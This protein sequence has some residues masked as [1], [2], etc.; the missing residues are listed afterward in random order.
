MAKKSKKV[1]KETRRLMESIADLVKKKGDRYKFKTKSKKQIKRIKK[2]C[3][4]WITRK[5][6]DVP[7]VSKDPNNPN[8]WKC[9][10]C[11]STFPVEPLKLEEYEAATAS[12]LSLVNQIQFYSVK[13]GGD[14]SDTKMFLNLKQNLPRFNRVAK[15]V[16]KRVNQRQAWEQNKKK[17]GSLDQFS[18]YGGFEYKPM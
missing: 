5:G 16:L 6:K 14:A 8:N 12:M 4:H 10:I 9:N 3:P 7:T 18:A 13:L 17:S 2:T 15:Q 1:E 11:G